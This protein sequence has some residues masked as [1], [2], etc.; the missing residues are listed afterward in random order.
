MRLGMTLTSNPNDNSFVVSA[1]FAISFFNK[2]KVVEWL[3][4]ADCFLFQQKIGYNSKQTC[5]T[6]GAQES[7]N[8]KI[9]CTPFHDLWLGD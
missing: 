6:E 1:P 3:N 8:L 4:G 7:P 9:H 5:S 2:P